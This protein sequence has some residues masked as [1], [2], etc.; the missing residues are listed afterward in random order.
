MFAAMDIHLS[1]FN[2]G[3][4]TRRGSFITGL[5]HGV[6]TVGTFGASTSADMLARNG[7]AFLLSSSKSQD[8]F[9]ALVC[10]LVKDP[11]KRA[12]IGIN[13]QRFYE[14]EFAWDRVAHRLF[15]IISSSANGDEIS[16]KM[17]VLEK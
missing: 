12:A 11:V 7:Q 10:D 1:T 15:Q 17:A 5:Q 16:T 2:D 13:G 9:V 4:S 14:L 3:I 6:P 8:Q